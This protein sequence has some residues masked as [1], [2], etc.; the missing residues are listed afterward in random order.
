V[1]D[2]LV[3]QAWIQRAF[4]TGTPVV[5]DFTIGS[6]S[7]K[8]IAP[9][10]F[11]VRGPGGDIVGVLTLSVD[12]ARLQAVLSE[13]PLPDGSVIAVLDQSGRVLARTREAE[14]Y[15]GTI[16]P[17]TVS[18]GIDG[19]TDWDDVD[20]T[21]RFHGDATTTLV[22]WVVRVGIPQS[23]VRRRLRNLWNRNI[24]IAGGAL[25]GS[26]L[27][28]LWLASLMSRHIG[29]LRSSAQQIAAGNLASPMPTATI[30]SRE[31][32]NLQESFSTMAGSLRETRARLEQQFEQERLMNDA[33][34]SLQRQVVRQ[35]RLAAVGLLASGV[36]HELNNPLQAIVGA[37]Q[38]LER[39]V[40]PDAQ[41]EVSVVKKQSAR[42]VAIIRSLARFGS[43]QHAEPSR[44]SLVDVVEDVVR[45]HSPDPDRHPI[46]LVTAS[47]RRDRLVEVS[48]AEVEQV[49]L[50][51]VL[52]ARHAVASLPPGEGRIE[53]Q[54]TDVAR[55]VRLE[56]R[57]NGVGVKPDDE[58]KLFQP[59][60]TTKSVGEGTGLG[61][62][63]SY[64]IIQ[65][66]GG[67]IGYYQNEWGG[68]TFFFE[69][70]CTDG[71]I[72]SDGEQAV[73]R[74]SV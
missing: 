43:Q 51:F 59:F 17:A 47:A 16:Q 57:D 52:N 61:L 72:T 54:V 55:W 20:G 70:P 22:P 15:V 9:M 7:A 69:L 37:A 49:I 66:H 5:G 26:M 50:N 28:A 23:E 41:P 33:L 14:K 3:S 68:A 6:I 46:R 45:L 31:L 18:P 38:L 39:Q 65:S 34:Q 53:V 73:L 1:Q 4:S 67:T 56:V 35:E 11:P 48:Y 63:V 8:P 30:P 27:L 21:Q 32:A 36:A 58:A 25:A 13:I 74:R 12:L 42:A 19:I 24:A 44:V 40:P 60:F 10:A 29:E 62:S 64:G 2:G 71:E